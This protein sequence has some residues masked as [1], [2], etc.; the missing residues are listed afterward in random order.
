MALTFRVSADFPVD[1]EAGDPCVHLDTGFRCS[2]HARLRPEGYAGCDTY[3]CFGAGQRISQET[4]GG[5]S[6]RE[7]PETSATMF[8]VLPVV[9]Q[10]H[11]L[12]WYLTEAL[13]LPDTAS[14]QAELEAL[15]TTVDD[16][17]GGAPETLVDLDVTP[18][19]ART[20]ELLAE[21]SRL[22]RA[23]ERRRARGAGRRDHRRA[24]LAGARLAG[25]DLRGADLRGAWLMGADLRGADL[26]RADLLGTD[27]RDADLTGADLSTALFVTQTQVNAA[28]GDVR[29]RLPEALARPRRWACDEDHASR[30]RGPS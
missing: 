16:L 23:G 30:A 10:L 24:D 9:R 25:A 6:W 28:R 22:A 7:R 17:A 21:T 11:E 3:D 5:A 15:C 27:L 13:T 4:F 19:R 2:I 12:L 20:G 8:A 26:R 29:T 1:K 18:W 14:L